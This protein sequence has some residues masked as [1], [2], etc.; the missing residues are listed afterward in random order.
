MHRE[1]RGHR[2]G[3]A[4]FLQEIYGAIEIS[5]GAEYAGHWHCVSAPARCE[6]VD[7]IDDSLRI[8]PSA[9]RSIDPANNA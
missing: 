7:L 4:V 1:E 6:S 2:A 5:K 8:V 3:S 9:E